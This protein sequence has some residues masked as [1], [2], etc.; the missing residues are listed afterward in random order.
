MQLLYTDFYVR[1]FPLRSNEE[2]C[3]LNDKEKLR[4]TNYIC[5]FL[6]EYT[7]FVG[8]YATS[9][10]FDFFAPKYALMKNSLTLIST[11]IKTKLPLNEDELDAVN[12]VVYMY[13]LKWIWRLF[14]KPW[15]FRSGFEQAQEN[16]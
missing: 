9:K 3:D 10:S 2:I 1:H 13:R 6:S 7:H 4:L 8:I 15:D 12:F 16:T 5:C 11:K 14:R